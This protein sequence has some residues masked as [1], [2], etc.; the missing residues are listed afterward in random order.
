MKVHHTHTDPLDQAEWV[1]EG[2]KNQTISPCWS[3]KT[4][5]D[6]PWLTGYRSGG[7][8]TASSTNTQRSQPA[9]SEEKLTAVWLQRVQWI[10]KMLYGRDG[11]KENH[12][13]KKEQ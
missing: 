10:Y 11:T 2:E 4:N 3:D 6:N 9:H 8:A 1:R 7:N 13:D 12:I 5:Y